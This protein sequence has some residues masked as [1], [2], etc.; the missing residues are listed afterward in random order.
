VYLTLPVAPDLHRAG[1]AQAVTD[2]WQRSWP[3]PPPHVDGG[4]A[5]RG[6]RGGRREHEMGIAIAIG[7]HSLDVDDAAAGDP[8]A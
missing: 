7:I 4:D 2:A 8:A 3:K 6:Y 5:G 1:G